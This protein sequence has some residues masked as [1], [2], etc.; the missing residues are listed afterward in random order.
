[1]IFQSVGFMCMGMGRSVFIVD[2]WVRIE[3]CRRRVVFWS[4]RVAI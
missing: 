3:G 2:G 1:M 4:M